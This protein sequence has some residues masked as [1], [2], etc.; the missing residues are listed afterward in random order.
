MINIWS[1]DIKE[2]PKQAP[3][4]TLGIL[5]NTN[6]FFGIAKQA[7]LELSV[8]NLDWLTFP[9]SLWRQETRLKDSRSQFPCD[10]A[11]FLQHHFLDVSKQEGLQPLVSQGV[12]V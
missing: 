7:T 4:L 11:V 8:T 9:N 12:Y 1:S 10:W 6:D 3:L 5:K 2:N